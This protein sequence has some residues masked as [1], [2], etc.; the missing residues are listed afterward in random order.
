MP[1]PTPPTPTPG[2]GTPPPAAPDHSAEIAT[3]KTQ[4]AGI[5]EAIAKLSGSGTP[6]VPKPAPDDGNL[7][8]KAKKDREA[9]EAEREK[10]KRMEAA[11]AFNLKAADFLKTNESLLPKD[12]PEIFERAK[13]ETYADAIEKDSAIKAGM[14]QSF[15]SVQSNVDLLTASQ[16]DVLDGYL[17]LT[18]TEKQ[19]RAQSFYDAVFEPTFE[20]LKSMKRAEALKKGHGNASDADTRF[21]NKMIESS[22]KHYLGAKNA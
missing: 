11:I 17:K 21:K 6:P 22:T 3:L 18:Q 1:D 13:K 15:F 14:I 19:A 2:P 5:T 9:L 7:H 10:N 4:L 8:D 12:V 16:K 20:H